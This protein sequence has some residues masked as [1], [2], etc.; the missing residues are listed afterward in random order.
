[1]SKT[2]YKI[3]ISMSFVIIQAILCAP[4]ETVRFVIKDKKMCQGIA[5]FS[6]PMFI[7]D[8]Y[9]N[10]ADDDSYDGWEPAKLMRDSA[11]FFAH[12][13][14]WGKAFD[15]K[16]LK[17]WYAPVRPI[18]SSNDPAVTWIGHSTFLIQFKGFNIVTDPVFGS[19]SWFYTRAVKP[20]I[21]PNRLPH[22]DIILLSHNH[23]DH[24]DE[25]SLMSLRGHQPLV[26]VPC[27]NASWFNENGFNYVLEYTWWE[28]QEIVLK[29]GS[30][31]LTITCVPAVHWSGRSLLDTNSALWSGWVISGDKHT[32]YFAGDTGY[33]KRQFDEIHT[34]FPSV[35]L[36]LLP[37]GPNEP[38]NLISSVHMSAAEAVDAF[39]DL[40]A[41]WFIPMHWGT[42]R[43]GTDTFNAPIESLK[44]AWQDNNLQDDRL[45]ILKFGQRLVYNESV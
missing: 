2:Y 3:L 25:E 34:L 37:I 21:A 28:N 26:M 39:L 11:R 38:R 1:M 36:A 22:I 41:Q 16:V 13:K 5:H 17:S 44:K 12:T 14:T 40:E 9:Y 29:N 23:S 8:Q 18:P 42:F 19:P 6:H 24:M 20:G 15:A 7:D 33:S 45:H 4:T 27:G 30:L 35:T 10:R 32:I 43:F 31:S